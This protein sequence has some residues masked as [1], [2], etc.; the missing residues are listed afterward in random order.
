MKNTEKESLKPHIL[1][2]DGRRLLHIEGLTDTC[3]FEDAIAVFYT[4]CGMV[5]VKGKNLHAE[6]L[7]LEKGELTLAG[8]INSIVYGDRDRIR[9]ATITEKIAR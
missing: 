4:T 5:T 2:L 8:E 6:D 9:R 1:T 3:R 7:S